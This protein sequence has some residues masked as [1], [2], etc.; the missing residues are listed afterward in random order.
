MYFKAIESSAAKAA[1]RNEQQR[2]LADER[3]RGCAINR[4]RSERKPEAAL[5]R[6]A[7]AK[8]AVRQADYERM[9]RDPKFNAPQG[10]FHKPGSL[11]G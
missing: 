5:P 11:Q 6:K 7:G 8:L 3:L 1:Q 2:K 9:I 4:K 10:A